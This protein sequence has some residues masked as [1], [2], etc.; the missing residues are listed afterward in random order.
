IVGGSETPQR[1]LAD[2]AIDNFTAR[3]PAAI[4]PIRPATISPPTSSLNTFDG[5]EIPNARFAAERALLARLR[6]LDVRRDA[7]P[8][9]PLIM[10]VTIFRPIVFIRLPIFENTL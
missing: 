1:P 6:S 7:E 9:T 4:P 2:E 5:E 10:P 8:V 3:S